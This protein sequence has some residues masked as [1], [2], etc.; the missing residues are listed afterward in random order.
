MTDNCPDCGVEIGHPHRNGCDIE[1]CSACGTQKITCDC[2]DHKP[3]M[4]L[5]T[6]RF[7]VEKSTNGS[8]DPMHPEIQD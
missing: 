4:S 3:L 5:W 6:G 8:I 7:P 2:K 1:R